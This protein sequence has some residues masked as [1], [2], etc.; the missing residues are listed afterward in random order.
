MTN[1]R[2]TPLERLRGSVIRYESPLEPAADEE[3]WSM[4]GTEPEAP[5]AIPVWRAAIALFGGNRTAADRWLH[6]EAL[7]L[8]GRRPIDVMRDDPQQVLEL[9]LR[10]DYGVYT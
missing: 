4:L 1:R 2:D 3:D 9:I 8:D 10:L 6:Q 5:S 7:A